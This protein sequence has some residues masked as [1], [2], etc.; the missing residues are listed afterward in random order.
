MPAK[1]PPIYQLTFTLLDTKPTIWRRIQIHT[2]TLLP[3]T[4]TSRQ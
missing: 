1:A 2:F 4:L 3:P